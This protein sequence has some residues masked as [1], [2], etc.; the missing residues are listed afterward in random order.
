MMH[1]CFCLLRIENANAQIYVCI[2]IYTYTAY[3]CV[4]I[5]IYICAYGCAIEPHSWQFEGE[6]WGPIFVTL[7]KHHRKGGFKA[8]QC[9]QKTYGYLEWPRLGLWVFVNF[10]EMGGFRVLFCCPENT[11]FLVVSGSHIQNAERVP[12]CTIHTCVLF[13]RFGCVSP[14]T[15]FVDFYS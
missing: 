14:R 11:I 6:W 4:Y 8:S 10:D 12:K 5:Y 15:V 13:G 1:F 9:H 3:M 7:R 2:Y